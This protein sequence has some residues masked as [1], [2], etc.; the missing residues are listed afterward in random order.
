MVNYANTNLNKVV[1][2]TFVSDKIYF[3]TN[4]TVRIKETH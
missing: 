4:K 3:R 2:V 1:V